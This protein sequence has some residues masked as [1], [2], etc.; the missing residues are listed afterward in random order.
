LRRGV[1]IKPLL[2][3]ALYGSHYF[4]FLFQVYA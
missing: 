1:L 3:L 2:L 4:F